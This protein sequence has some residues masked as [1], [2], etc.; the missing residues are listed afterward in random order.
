[1]PEA[2]GIRNI[3]TGKSWKANSGKSVWAKPGHAKAAWKISHYG[4]RDRNRD[5][6]TTDT[7]NDQELWEVFAIGQDEAA[8]L[9][10]AI[11]LL[12]AVLYSGAITFGDEFGDF[13]SLEGEIINFL[14]EIG[15]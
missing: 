1:M 5:G 13:E 3:A 8:L 15:Q 10:R 9:N 2:F 11:A 7:F 6:V 4:T 12:E 14:R